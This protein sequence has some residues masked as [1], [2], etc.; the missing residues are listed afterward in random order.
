MNV[1]VRSQYVMVPVTLN[2]ILLSLMFIR[3]IFLMRAGMNYS[4]YKDKFAAQLW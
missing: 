4:V 3:I 2:S 1:S